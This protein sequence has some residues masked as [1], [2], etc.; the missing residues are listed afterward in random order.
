[1]LTGQG[2]RYNHHIDPFDGGPH[3]EA[4]TE[5]IPVVRN[6]QHVQSDTALDPLLRAPGI[7]LLAAGH[8]NEWRCASAS[9]DAPPPAGATLQTLWPEHLQVLDRPDIVDLTPL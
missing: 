9:L 3:Y 2:F 8:G 1:M 6:L 7:W 5:D 4:R